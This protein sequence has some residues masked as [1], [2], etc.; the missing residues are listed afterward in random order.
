MI[1]LYLEFW[2]IQFPYKQV[3]L[4]CLFFNNY[5]ESEK[6]VECCACCA[7]RACTIFL[8]ITLPLLF[9]SVKICDPFVL[10]MWN[11]TQNWKND[12]L[13]GFSDIRGILQDVYIWWCILRNLF[14]KYEMLKKQGLVCICTCTKMKK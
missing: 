14:L 10:Q 11:I 13:F 9:T 12:I 1:S 4:Y 7:K 5:R 8:I 2:L 3:I 6:Q